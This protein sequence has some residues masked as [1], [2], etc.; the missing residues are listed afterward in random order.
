MALY[1]GLVVSIFVVVA[2]LI[3][4]AVVVCRRNSR[5]FDTRHLDSS[6]ALTGGFH[7]STSRLQG[8]VRTWEHLG[9]WVRAGSPG[10]GSPGRRGG[11]QSRGA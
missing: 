5:D 6:A 1:A 8:P 3:V 11:S 4:V 10:L 7:Q 9:W 2:V